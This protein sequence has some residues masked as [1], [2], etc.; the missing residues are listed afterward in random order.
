MLPVRIVSGAEFGRD[1]RPILQDCTRCHGG[2]KRQSGLSFLARE[3]ALAPTRSH[4]RAI[5]PGKPNE[6]ELLRR[7]SATGRERM[8]PDGKPLSPAQVEALRQ[9]IEAGA[10]WDQHWPSRQQH[11]RRRPP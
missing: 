4:A 3:D 7:V 11:A 1:I 2:I 5:V 6:S 9:W 10:Q 8:P